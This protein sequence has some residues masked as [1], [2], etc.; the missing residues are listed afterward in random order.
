MPAAIRTPA[1]SS[2]TA[3]T[4]ATTDTDTLVWQVHRLR[5]EPERIPLIA[6][7]F[8]VTTALWWIVFPSV[9]TLPLPILCLTTALNDFLFP[10]RFRLTAQGAHSDGGISHLFIAWSDVKR[11][12]KGS[13]GVYL[14]PFARPT[15]LEAF[16]GVRLRFVGNADEVIETVKRLRSDATLVQGESNGCR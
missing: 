5:E 13:D 3:A 15:R 12:T 6:G 11:V 7:A 10:I 1:I 14:S 4:T 2:S 8:A 9:L 16:R